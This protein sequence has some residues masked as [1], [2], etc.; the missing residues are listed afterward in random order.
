MH[1]EKLKKFKAADEKSLT[2]TAT[3]IFDKLEEM[4]NVK[5]FKKNNKIC[6]EKHS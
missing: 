2:D 1:R 6:V 3:T 4:I 5:N